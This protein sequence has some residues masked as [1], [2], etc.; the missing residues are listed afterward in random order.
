VKAE[1][2]TLDLDREDVSFIEADVVDADGTIV[3]DAH[4][5]VRFEVS[6]PGRLLGGAMEID[7]ITGVV[8]INVQTTGR[9][10]EIVVTAAAPKLEPG[11]VHIRVP[12]K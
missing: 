9:P 3:P 2:E 5:W 10:G 12:A 7:A 1:K 8:A 11:S 4:P 6:G